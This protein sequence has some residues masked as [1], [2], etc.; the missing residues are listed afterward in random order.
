ME[1]EVRY[2]FVIPIYNEEA[3]L[4]EL[5]RRV[6][7]FIDTL[8]GQAE[9]IFVDDG[10]RDGSLDMMREIAEADPRF[11]Y[12][13]LSRN[14]GHQIAITAGMDFA[15]GK[16]IIIMDA[17]LQDPPEVVL[18][19]IGK[20][21]EGY[22]IVYGVREE[23]EGETWFKRTT[24]TAFYRMLRKV[25]DLDVP[26]DVGDFRLVD[27]AALDAFRALREK[28]RYVRGLFSWIG[29]KQTGVKYKRAARFA[30]DTKYP[31][32]KMLKLATDG[33]LS[34]SMFPL[35]IALNAGF[36]IAGLAFVGGIWAIVEKLI[37]AYVVPGWVSLLVA[38]AFLGGIQLIILGIMGEYIGRIYE[39]VKNRPL[40]IVKSSTTQR[41]EQ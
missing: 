23:R 7:D 14:Y 22:D 10:S 8:D 30:G 9:V 28:N 20:W 2:S 6:A 18:E 36:W 35:R 26:V 29:F 34:F 33:V 32:S 37:G 25:T 19:M 16:A 24:A 31:L 17:D 39:E 5:A 13:E 40:Y 15:S 1:S 41:Q 11:K 3:T 38:V 21:K 12:V 4:Q 27:R